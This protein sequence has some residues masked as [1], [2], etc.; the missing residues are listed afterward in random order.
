MFTKNRDRLLEGAVSARFLAELLA[1]PRV[2]ALLSQDHFS[3]DGTQIKAWASVKSFH[4]KEPGGDGGN[5]TDGEDGT[6]GG[7]ESGCGGNNDTVVLVPQ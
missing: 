4:P 6:G 2:K 1:L 3:V 7:G 5:G